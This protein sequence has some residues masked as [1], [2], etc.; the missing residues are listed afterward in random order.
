MSGYFNLE[1]NS[2]MM[3]VTPSHTLNKPY[4][5]ARKMRLTA[6]DADGEM[7]VWARS[8][9]E[10]RD[11]LINALFDLIFRGARIGASARNP[12][13]LFCG[14]QT[15]RHGRNSSGTRTWKCGNPECRR[16]FVL[17]RTFRGGIN[18]PTQSK[19][20]AFIRLLLAGRTV[21]EAADQLRL[22]IHTASGWAE[23]AAATGLLDGK[24][25]P[26]GKVLR[27]RG[28]CAFRLA[29]K[30]RRGDDGRLQAEGL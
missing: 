8:D 16:S 1:L 18:H 4:K 28:V 3:P 27:H 20:P 23:H 15:Q 29:H 26:C 13:C 10:A 7:V 14:G 5:G 17:D 11:H 22:G 19:K 9:E 25:C 21:R 30:R 2:D 6:P 12:R 24:L